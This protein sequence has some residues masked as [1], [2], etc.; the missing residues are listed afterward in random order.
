MGLPNSSYKRIILACQA[1][2]MP[3]LFVYTVFIEPQWLRG[4][5]IRLN[6]IDNPII[7][8]LSGVRLL[9][10]SDF[11]INRMGK[12][13]HKALELIDKLS[14]DIIFITG[15][16]FD[17]AGHTKGA[18]EFMDQLK[19]PH[20]V[21]GVLG[22]VDYKKPENAE[23][24]YKRYCMGSEPRQT[25]TMLKNEAL[26]LS[27]AG[28][29]IQIIG[30][31]DPIIY[32]SMEEYEKAIVPLF[33]AINEEIPTLLLAHRPDIFSLAREKGVNFTLC[34][35][36][37]GGQMRL[38]FSLQFYN[39]SQATKIYNRGL[40]RIGDMLMHVSPGI[41][42]SDIPMRFLCR[43]EETLFTFS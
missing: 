24:L 5:Q 17:Y 28:F 19:A 7:K 4:R 39:Q 10:L 2:F 37:H 18:I 29:P 11:H 26:F 1:L 23:M 3:P 43:P 31:N 13:E 14:P 20:G 34:G 22:N 42:T 27:P 36:T 16:Y 25:F 21:F 15:D 32:K 9:H 35:H 41:G 8:A 38:P 40:Y 6:G 12:R 33:G 30:I